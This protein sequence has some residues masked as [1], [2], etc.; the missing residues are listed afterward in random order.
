M[1]ALQLARLVVAVALFSLAVAPAYAAR[2]QVCNACQQAVIAQPA[3]HA[4]QFLAATYNFVG[5]PVRL[6]AEQQYT[7]QNDPR[8]EQFQQY[9]AQQQAQAMAQQLFEQWKAQALGQQPAGAA[10]PAP[11]TPPAT[12]GYAEP[13]AA[14]TAPATAPGPL[15]APPD[16]PPH[17]AQPEITPHA[18][19]MTAMVAACA[20]CHN[21]NKPE[22][23]YVF[24]GSIDYTVT[25]DGLA[26]EA[27]ALKKV[28]IMEEIVSQRMPKN[29]A[30]T[31]DEAGQIVVELFGEQ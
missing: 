25:G 18:G 30:L 24:D 12:P 22:G 13:P 1:I 4:Q 16:A 17:V 7:M 19:K 6:Q 8:Y 28:R 29:R 15:P 31:P 5:A 23:G 11:E 10:Q 26:A 3:Y 21:T 2:H 27:M 9:L 14:P 20:S